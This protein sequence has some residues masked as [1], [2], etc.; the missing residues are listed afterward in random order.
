MTV[1]CVTILPDKRGTE[2]DDW[3]GPGL[4]FSY[5]MRL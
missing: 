2:R 4:V 5:T 1:T 3:P